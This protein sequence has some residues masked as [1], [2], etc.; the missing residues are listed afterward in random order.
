MRDTVEPHEEK[1]TVAD[2]EV[3]TVVYDFQKLLDELDKEAAD[4]SD[5]NHTAQ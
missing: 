2:T 3:H 5:A 4:P 1:D